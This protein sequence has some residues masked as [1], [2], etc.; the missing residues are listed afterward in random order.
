MPKGDLPLT[1]LN[2]V[3]TGGDPVKA[4]V[5][6]PAQPLIGTSRSLH[7]WQAASPSACI[8]AVACIVGCV[9]TIVSNEMTIRR[10]L[11]TFAFALASITARKFVLQLS[12][13]Q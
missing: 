1:D 4:A 9:H 6:T 7:S 2:K 3:E 10:F 11:P 13:F 5:A 12:C 8:A